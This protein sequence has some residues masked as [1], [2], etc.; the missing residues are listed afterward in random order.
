MKALVL[1]LFSV[2]GASAIAYGVLHVLQHIAT[3]VPQ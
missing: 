1:F 2:A 3:A